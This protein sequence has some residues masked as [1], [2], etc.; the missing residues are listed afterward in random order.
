[1]KYMKAAKGNE[2]ISRVIRV[3]EDSVYK[4]TDGRKRRSTM[5]VFLIICY[6]IVYDRFQYTDNMDCSNVEINTC[7]YLIN[8][9][10]SFV[11]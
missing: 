4:F 7:T 5:F 1:M 10:P 2:K 8:S 11:Y 9:F 3:L 6:L